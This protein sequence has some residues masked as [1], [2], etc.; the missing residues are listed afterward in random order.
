[1]L[2]KLLKLDIENRLH[3]VNLKLANVDPSDENEVNTLTTIKKLHEA[4]LEK[5]HEVTGQ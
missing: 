3:S 1:M 5:W 2:L 4:Q